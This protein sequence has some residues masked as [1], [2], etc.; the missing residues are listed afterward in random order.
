MNGITVVDLIQPS[1]TDRLL[2][3]KPKANL[4]REVQNYLA[5]RPIKESS[6][7]AIERLLAEYKVTAEE[8]RPAFAALYMTVVG[9]F[10]KDY[11]ISDDE[12]DELHHLQSVLGLSAAEIRD[13]E[14][15][16]VVPLFEKTIQN[17]LSDR[18]VS[19]EER[20]RM[21][22]AAESLR[23][24]ESKAKAVYALHA[25][26]MFQEV[27]DE[28]VSDRRLS[29]GEEMELNTL[30]QNLG[31]KWEHDQ[32]T[33]HVLD[34]FRLLWRISQGL[35]PQESVAIHLQKGETCALYAFANHYE[36]RTVTKRV[37]YHGPRASIKIMKGVRWN[38]G[39]S[40]SYR[41]TE[42]VWRHLGTGELYFTNKRL[43]FDGDN[44][45]VN[46]PHKKII[47]FTC[48]EDGL[49]I[50]KDSG[51]D[52]FFAFRG[53]SEIVGAIM[54]ALLERSRA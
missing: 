43:I 2:R 34:R 42:D 33:A 7:Q 25:Q 8:A 24:S 46:I 3:R 35:L 12:R 10:A 36:M 44:K 50:E 16:V 9:H 32:A 15:K 30:A 40:S 27:F 20:E 6:P 41:H 31:A 14:E 13:M 17:V 53:D 45:T 22:Q 19:P 38:V 47:D 4:A 48:Y 26:E 37:T 18:H 54:N 39:S 28:M 52:Q 51:K 29:P 23:I 5:G 1:V 21:R 11:E 49:L